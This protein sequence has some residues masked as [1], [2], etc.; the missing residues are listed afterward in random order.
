MAHLDHALRPDSAADSRFVTD[1]A[2][3][4]GLPCSVERRD[5]RAYART[6]G[7]SLEEAGR[8]QRYAFL[9]QV[10][11]R[12]RAEFIALGHHADDQAETVIM[13]PVARQWCHRLRGDGDCARGSLS[14]ATAARA[15]R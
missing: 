6:E 10:A 9:D 2:K 8:R 7:L 5:V 12:V 13:P 11:D 3:R 14:A 4:R 15:A 1:E